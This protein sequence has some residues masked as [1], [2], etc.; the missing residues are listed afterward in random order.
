MG[1]AGRARNAFGSCAKG[2]GDVGVGGVVP[3]PVGPLVFVDFAFCRRSGIVWIGSVV[4]LVALGD[5][6]QRFGRAEDGVAGGGMANG[7]AFDAVLLV[8]K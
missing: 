6:A 1:D 8:I 4:P 7:F 3:S 5:A 2:K